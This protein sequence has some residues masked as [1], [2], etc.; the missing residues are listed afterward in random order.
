VEIPLRIEQAVARHLEIELGRRGLLLTADALAAAAG[1]AAQGGTRLLARTV[2]ECYPGEDHVIEFDSGHAASRVEAAL[3]FGSATAGVLTRQLDSSVELICAVFNLGIGLIDG[4]CDA[5]AATGGALLELVHERDLVGAAEEPAARG[6]LRTTVPPHLAHD[7]TVAFTVAII[8][9]FFDLLH[10]SYRDGALRR[11][12]GTQLEAALEAERRSVIRPA[13]QTPRELIE[14]SRSTSVL[15]FRIIETLAGGDRAPAG[16]QLGE[17][18][19]RID[20][21]VDLCDDARS[22]SLNGILLRAA[23][24]PESDVVDE[25]ELLV[26]PMAA[27]AAELLR[28]GLDDHPNSTMFLHFIQRYAGI[29]PS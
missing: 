20:D 12:V 15:P 8:E 13:E 3:A 7:P 11:T 29:A 2:Q 1:D 28:G 17:A 21:L 5:D 23:D 25:V 6:W 18:M 27:E 4:L 16:T 9:A 14:V 26:R 19:W 10:A 22:G 24:S